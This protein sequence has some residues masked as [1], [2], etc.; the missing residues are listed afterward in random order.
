[1]E[2]EL[3]YS[4]RRPPTGRVLEGERPCTPIPALRLAQTLLLNHLWLKADTAPPHC[5]AGHVGR[6]SRCPQGKERKGKRRTRT[7]LSGW[8]FSHRHLG[9]PLHPEEGGPG[10]GVELEGC[11]HRQSQGRRPSCARACCPAWTCFPASVLSTDACCTPHHCPQTPRPWPHSLLPSG[12]PTVG[13]KHPATLI[14]LLTQ[15]SP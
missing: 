7:R 5:R 15:A 6:S 14:S 1:M 11:V 13:F 10:A 9:G 8:Q 3:L 12:K 2:A 4:L